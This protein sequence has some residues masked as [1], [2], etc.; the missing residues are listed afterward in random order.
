MDMDLAALQPCTI[1]GHKPLS[2]CNSDIHWIRLQAS[3]FDA[4]K[5]LTQ[6]SG[7]TDAGDQGIKLV[8]ME[9]QGHRMWPWRC[10]IQYIVD[11]DDTFTDEEAFATIVQMAQDDTNL[12]LSASRRWVWDLAAPCIVRLALQ[13]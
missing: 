11:G 7:R 3:Y 6:L 9:Y 12:A 2:V 10:T 4:C 1:V 5:V 8:A 13:P